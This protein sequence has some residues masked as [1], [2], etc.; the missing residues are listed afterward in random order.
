MKIPMKIRV[1]DSGYRGDC[2]LESAELKTF[3]NQIR[4]KYPDTW[5][6]LAFHT[7]N[8][9]K[10]SHAQVQVEKMEGAT[11]GVCDIIVAPGFYCELK[12]RDRTKSRLPTVEKQFL[13]LVAE[14]GGFACVAYGWEQA[15]VAF[16]DWREQ[17]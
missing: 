13:E 15:W 17:Q 11:A 5:G 12:R 2:P 1:Y 6:K 8:E 9:G 10:K 3:F 7:R 4:G 16:N 14:R